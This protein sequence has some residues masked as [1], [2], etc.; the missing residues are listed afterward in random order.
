MAKK[1]IHLFTSL[2]L[3]SV[4]GGCTSFNSHDS[5]CFVS[6]PIYLS[7]DDSLTKQT[8]RDLIKHNESYEALCAG[9]LSDQTSLR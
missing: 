4:L 9:Y 6:K 2:L 7:K 5:F 8:L 3:A 1:T